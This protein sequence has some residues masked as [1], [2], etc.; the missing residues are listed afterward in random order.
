MSVLNP[1]EGEI[2]IVAARKQRSKLYALPDGKRRLVTS[3]RLLHWRDG[4][5]WVPIDPTPES[6]DGGTTWK[7]RSGPY[8]ITY[9]ATA[10]QLEYRSRKGGVARVTLKKVG[11]VNFQPVP[12]SNVRVEGRRIITVVGTDTEIEFRIYP[13]GVELFKVI[14][15]QA[16]AHKFSWEWIVDKQ[17]SF[18]LQEETRAWDNADLAVKRRPGLKASRFME[19]NVTRTLI[20]EN[21]DFRRVRVDEE[22][23]G[24]NLYVDSVTKARSYV[25]G[26]VVF[27]VLIDD[28]VSEDIATDDDDGYCGETYEYWD[29]RTCYAAG[30][31]YAP[32]QTTFG[33]RWD[34]VAIDQGSDVTLAEVTYNCDFTYGGTGDLTYK[35]EAS[36]DAPVW[37]HADAKGIWTMS[38]TTASALEPRPAS[39]GTYVVDVTDIVDE[40]VNRAGWASGNAIRIGLRDPDNLTSGQFQVED[41]NDAGTAEAN[42]S[43]TFS[44][45]ATGPSAGAFYH[46]Y[47]RNIGH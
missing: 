2:E 27:P 41:Y 13:R 22:L 16:G 4:D 14:N 38:V 45:P 7:I 35:G 11:N 39:T 46:H 34:G 36:D 6:I 10:C 32:N 19:L 37:N 15:S 25:S 5:Q 8:L 28:A 23:T 21:Q 24:R 42:L 17:R 40:I 26:E 1:R 12:V 3:R 20:N 43:V 29:N 30:S 47:Q 18:L 31:S 44:P 33:H 9:D